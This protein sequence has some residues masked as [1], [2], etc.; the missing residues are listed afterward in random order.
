MRCNW[1]LTKAQ[2]EIVLEFCR[3]DAIGVWLENNLNVP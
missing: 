3:L 1:N 2:F